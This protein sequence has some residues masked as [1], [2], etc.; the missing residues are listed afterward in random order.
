MCL[1][2]IALFLHRNTLFDSGFPAGTDMFGWLARPWTLYNTGEAFAVWKSG[3]LGEVRQ[4]N[5]ET[6]LAIATFLMRSPLWV[7]RLFLLASYLVA[8]VGV[9]ILA[10]RYTR[11]REASLAAAIIYVNS[12]YFVSQ[13]TSGH[14]N[15]AWAF[16]LA[17]F[18]F[19]TLDTLLVR[20]SFGALIRFV[21]VV[22][23]MT[24][25]IRT[26]TVFYYLPFMLVLVAVRLASAAW[27][28]RSLAPAVRMGAWLAA[29]LPIYLL[30]SSVVIIPMLFGSQPGFTEDVKFPLEMHMNNSLDPWETVQGRARELGYMGW[31]G[32][33]WWDR[34]SFLTGAQY[35]AVMLV[36]PILALAGWTARPTVFGTALLIGGVVSLF[37]AK[38]PHEPLARPYIWMYEHVPVFS[39]LRAPNRWLM[40]AYLSYSILSAYALAAT[41][42]ALGRGKAFI[43]QR[44][45]QRRAEN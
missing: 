43:R 26:E 18:L 12:Q 37:L 9:Y 6:V 22:F 16:G 11:R 40:M 8:G 29:S 2:A 44:W 4:Y 10:F 20:P 28:A 31:L 33:I 45:F 35:S 13:M 1:V 42:D 23:A 38:G 30:L 41:M 14:L 21:L 34:H 5:L 36:V 24:V 19:L 7:L 17:P 39:S 15:L 25:G 32:N 3:P 27:R